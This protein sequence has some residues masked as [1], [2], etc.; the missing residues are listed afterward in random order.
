MLE[1][2]NFNQKRL[3]PMSKYL[4]VGQG[5]GRGNVAQTCYTALGVSGD[6]T[7]IPMKIK[8]ANMIQE[9]WLRRRFLII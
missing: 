6:T 5:Q 4:D 7:I 3:H 8:L 1:R 9:M 2:G